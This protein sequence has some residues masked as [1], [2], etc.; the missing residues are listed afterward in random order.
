MVSILRF[1]IFCPKL[2]V[3]LY[4]WMIEWMTLLSDKHTAPNV[5]GAFIDRVNSLYRYFVLNFPNF[6]TLPTS[7][8]ANYRATFL[9]VTIYFL[10]QTTCEYFL[11]PVPTAVLFDLLPIRGSYIW[12]VVY[13]FVNNQSLGVFNMVHVLLP[14]FE[15]ALLV[16]GS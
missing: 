12:S 16:S 3:Y 8:G 10:C 14:S 1:S 5:V 7:R 11:R 13:H 4:L 6:L 15:I 9:L 2:D